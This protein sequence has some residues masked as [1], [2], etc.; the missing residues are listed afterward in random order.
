MTKTGSETILVVDD[1]H[2]TLKLITKIL[3]PRGYQLL[4]ATSGEAALE[5]ATTG[6]SD[7]HLLLTDVVLPEMNGRDLAHEFLTICPRAKV[8]FMSGY[9]CPSVAHQDVPD[10]EKAFVRKPFTAKSLISKLRKVL[11]SDFRLAEA[12]QG[13][14]A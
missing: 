12:D 13:S 8:L 4:T 1:D 11:K 14:V 6:A 7:I 2:N 9:L 3:S 5:L 10:S